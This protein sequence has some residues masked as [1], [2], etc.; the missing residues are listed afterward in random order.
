MEKQLAAAGIEEPLLGCT[1]ALG[2]GAG[3]SRRPEEV[4]TWV[5]QHESE[6]SG[7]ERGAEPELELV[8][9]VALDDADLAAPGLLAEGENF[10]RTHAGVGLTEEDADRCIRLLVR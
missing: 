10:I 8:R 1:I 2:A 9:F 4:R 6:S 3:S 7:G 5:R